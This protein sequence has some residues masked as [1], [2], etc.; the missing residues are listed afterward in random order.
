MTV[1]AAVD[2]SAAA[3]PV[4][5]TALAVAHLSGTPVTALHVREGDGHTARGAADACAVPFQEVSGDVVG[6]LLANARAPHTETL[7]VGARGRPL[8]ARPAGHVAL[9][10]M[11]RVGIP[12]VL[13]PPR[14]EMRDRIRRLLVPLDGTP[15]T[16]R[17]LEQ[18]M[19]ICV[20]ADVDIVALHVF[21]HD[22]IPMFSNHPQY[23]TE[24]FTDAFLARCARSAGGRAHLELRVGVPADEILDAGTTL[25]VDLIA[26]GWSQQLEPGRA[27]VVRHLVEHGTVPVQ[28]V[29]LVQSNH[30]RPATATSDPPAVPVD[31]R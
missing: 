17:A 29:P 21:N 18:A 23:E 3:Y 7:V 6:Q 9:E 24:A 15:E 14:A 16:A 28:L 31:G 12:L 11:A 4:V 30:A 8:G 27:L 26:L 5:R 10:L 19:Q 22:H 2:N 1:V 25:D 20:A 13:V